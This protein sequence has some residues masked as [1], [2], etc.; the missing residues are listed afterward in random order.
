MTLL[1]ILLIGNTLDTATG[2]P[3]EESEIAKELQQLGHQVTV[4]EKTELAGASFPLDQDL[5]FIATCKEITVKHIKAII[6]NNPKAK[7]F[8]WMADF[9]DTKHPKIEVLLPFDVYKLVDVFL[10]RQVEGLDWMK[11]KGINCVY[12]PWD[13]A[14]NTFKKESNPRAVMY[15]G[16]ADK[17]PEVMPIG[18]VGNWV[19]D[20]FRMKFLYELQKFFPEDLHIITFS[21]R[22]FN[23]GQIDGEP[24][25][26]KLKNVHNPKNG[27]QFNKVVDMIKINLAVDSVISE[28]YT[29]NRMA[30]IM[31]AG[32]FV[33]AYYAKGM[34]KH[35]GDYIDYFHSLE[36]CVEKINYWLAHD[37]ERKAFAERG[38]LFAEANLRP[39]N[40]INQLMEI[41]EQTNQNFS[42]R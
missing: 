14:I 24:S 21:L 35:F 26:F 36:E 19:H 1:K 20:P 9:I 4:I 25:E 27:S 3:A 8:L 10:W 7:I 42:L 38:R 2:E 15:C 33:L 28:D 31:V 39:I 16:T 11:K 40:R 23:E 41:Y 30:R 5:V 29:S 37:E 6:R 18:F 12:W 13:V 32:G 22:E 34:E 17:I